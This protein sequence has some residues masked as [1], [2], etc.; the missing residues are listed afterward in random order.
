MNQ[1][2]ERPDDRALVE[3]AQAGDTTAF[4]E[5]VRRH[6][7]GLFSYIYRMTADRNTTEELCQ[8]AMV[9]AWKSIAGFGGRSGFKTW[10]YRIAINLTINYRTRRKPTCELDEELPA[11]R[12]TEPETAFRR[13]EREAAVQAALGQLPPDQRTAMVLSLYEQMSYREIGAA[14]GR[15]AR[16]V[17]SLLFRA[18]TNL[19]RLLE[20]AR[21]KGVI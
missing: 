2:A 12:E 15:S 13:R 14:M 19:R 5:L 6:Q 10:L 7:Q 16:A 18:K 8:Q 3:R 17:D 1:S 11:G 9:R 4:E 20:P 21:R